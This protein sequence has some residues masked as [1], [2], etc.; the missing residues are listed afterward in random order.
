MEH[1][2]SAK[3]VVAGHRRA[4]TAR[5]SLATTQDG[6]GRAQRVNRP[7]PSTTSNRTDSRSSKGDP[8][9]LGDQGRA[10]LVVLANE[11]GGR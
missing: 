5:G 1:R 11:V 4:E 3:W 8:E 9:L 10:R 6:P 7:G 2:R